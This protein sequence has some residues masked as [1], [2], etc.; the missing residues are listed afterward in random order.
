MLSF[1]EYLL[2][3]AVVEGAEFENY[4]I[5]AWNGTELPKLGKVDATA[6]PEIVAHLKSKN[7]HGTASKLSHGPDVTKD[8]SQFWRPDTVPGSTKTPKT[9][10]I[11]GNYKLSLKMGPAQLM[12]GGK[13]ESKATFY[14]AVKSIGNVQ[15]KLLSEIQEKLDLL[16]QSSIAAG[17][18]EGE[19]KNG[20]DQFLSKANDINNQVKALMKTAFVENEQFKRAFV[21]EAMTGETKFGNNSLATAGYVLS[22]DAKGKKPI[23]HSTKDNSFLDKVAQNATVTVRFKSTSVK[24]KG[25]K[26]G[27]YRY[28]S[29]IS[30]GV[31]KLQEELSNHN[32]V[33]TENI[34]TNIF[35]KVKSF[36]VNLFNK[37]I[38]W[39]KQSAQHIM[40]FF[41][42]EP[43]VSFKNKISFNV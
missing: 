33:L 40:E 22:T 3:E 16:T 43:D 39:M 17:Q 21:K 19:L 26:T 5:A 29:V 13:N 34:I 36:I 4:V 15:D 1:N 6:A 14:A 28:W 20:K 27:E 11:I 25:V 18:I 35:A 24:A 12:S 32:G 41:D 7:L 30:L 42:I 9:D 23:L 10:I 37:A 31:N 2:S 8:W 38:Q